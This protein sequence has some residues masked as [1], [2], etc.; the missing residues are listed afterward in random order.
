MKFF[1]IS[2]LF[3]IIK[4]GYSQEIS[5]IVIDSLNNEPIPF[6]AITSN[7]NNNTITNEEGKFR[8]FKDIPFS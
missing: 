1:K 4:F 8:I 3:L 6:A 2:I 5:G 7:F